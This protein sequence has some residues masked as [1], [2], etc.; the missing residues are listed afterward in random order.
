MANAKL[1][2]NFGAWAVI[3]ALAFSVGLSGR[4]DAQQSAG[5]ARPD[6]GTSSSSMEAMGAMGA[7]PADATTP[8]DATPVAAVTPARV[9][10][11]A[12]PWAYVRVDD[13]P[14]FVTPRAMPLELPPGT[15]TFAFEHPTYGREE[16]GVTLKPG[17]EHVVRHAYREASR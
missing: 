4:V 5:L 11:V 1:E 10:F 9:R 6:G 2:C 15:Y 3:V 14:A 8:D 13:Q 16:Y 17:E 12:Q 7:T